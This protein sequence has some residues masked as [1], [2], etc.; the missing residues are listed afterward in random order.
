MGDF[1]LWYSL[2]IGNN[3]IKL[4][5]CFRLNAL[6]RN[7]N[8]ELVTFLSKQGNREN[9]NTLAYRDWWVEAQQLCRFC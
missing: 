6:S 4:E 9:P 2:H 3:S 5:L 7:Q 8:T 1:V